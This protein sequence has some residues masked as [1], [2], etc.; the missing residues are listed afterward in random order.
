MASSVYPSVSSPTGYTDVNGNPV[1][2][3]GSAYTGSSSSGLQ[4]LTPAQ[5]K[6][7][8]VSLQ[9][10]PS[11]T[12]AANP[13][14]QTQYSGL[15]VQSTQEQP[16]VIKLAAGGL[17]APTYQYKQTGF[18][19]MSPSFTH[20]KAVQL[21]GT[22]GR[23]PVVGD[24]SNKLIGMHAGG[25]VPEGHNPEFFSEGGLQHAYVK[26]GGDGT[27][28][29]VPAMLATGEWVLPADV[30]SSLG[31][32]DNESGAKVLKEFMEVIRKHKRAADPK[33]LP[34]D[35]KGPLAYLLQAQKKV[36]KK[37]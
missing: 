11:I 2:A 23:T 28:D 24:M 21:Y 10:A 32:G 25:D 5:N 33:S 37:K 8:T 36:S 9:G 19:R 1:N 26:G 7:K 20:G 17:D 35:S 34:P 13:I 4:S 29:S 30:V 16:P 12:E 31:N 15:P 22:P 27:S 14:A 6:A 3:D 18:P